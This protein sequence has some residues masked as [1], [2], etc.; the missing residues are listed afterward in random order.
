MIA[1]SYRREDS[2][3][4]AGRLYDR[5]QARFGKE[6][7]FMD[8]DSIPA[9]VD[10]REQ[11]QETI[12]RS[13]VVVAVIGHQWFGE[14]GDGSRRIDD[15]NDFVRLEIEYALGRKIPII[16]LLVNNRSMPAPQ[17]LPEALSPLAFRNGLP[18]DSGRDFHNH[19]D[20]IVSGI[21]AAVERSG[22]IRSDNLRGTPDETAAE[23]RHGKASFFKKTWPWFLIAVA[24]L[25]ILA[26]LFLL[27]TS[28]REQATSSSPSLTLSVTPAPTQAMLN[29]ASPVPTATPMP[30]ST[31][32]AS[33]RPTP[34]ATAMTAST[35][36]PWPSPFASPSAEI[37]GS[38]PPIFAP[39]RRPWRLN[40][41]V[42]ATASPTPEEAVIAITMSA[43][44]HGRSVR[45]AFD[46]HTPTIYGLL[47][48]AGLKRQDELRAAWVTQFARSGKPKG[49]VVEEKKMMVFHDIDNDDYFAWRQ[50]FKE[51]WI[52]GKYRLEIYLNGK[53]M[54]HSDFTILKP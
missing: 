54:A 38:L 25:V 37:A 8:F 51:R 4:I 22:K 44:P 30:T 24:V 12:E 3:P 45:T 50:P 15:P 33:I 19:V 32:A 16:P 17:E 13:D 43:D 52:P 34:A 5:L 39:S 11:I 29:V 20:R 21:D 7:V 1:I 53:E 9:G 2:L 49:T 28:V 48:T 31:T 26:F 40:N 6:N 47:K 36:P 10:F 23:G 35:A 42:S 41:P 14:R 18:L 27:K 46:S